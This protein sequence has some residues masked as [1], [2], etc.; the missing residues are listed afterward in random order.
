MLKT[1]FFALL[2]ILVTIC[3]GIFAAHRQAFT[4]QDSKKFVVLIMDYALP[5]H[6]FSGIW[7]AP[8]KIIIEDMP[9]ALW[10]VVSM[11]GCYLTL[12]LLQ[13]KLLK[14]P[15]KTATLRALSIADPSVPFIGSAILPLLFG[16]SISAIAIGISTLIINIILLPL[17]F[18]SLVSDTATRQFNLIQRL[19][20]T[21]KK[22]LVLSALAGFALALLGWQMPPALES[23]FTVLG[24]TAGGVAM[25]AT[26]IV[27]YV[28][29]ISFNKR[30]ISIV[31]GKNIIFPCIIWVSMFLLNMPNA[32]QRIVVV[33]LAIPTATMP[34]N[35][36][37][38]YKVNESEMA[39][40]QFWSTVLSFASLSIFMLLLS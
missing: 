36:A 31:I 34:T 26:G 35:L 33:T 14:T 12:M 20:N 16:A 15:N 39:S 29:K 8:R 7:A 2:P 23:T 5:L 28:R 22:P 24:K 30:I 25:F 27:L 21:L 32:L 17:V 4:E 13:T 3:L 18:T 1:V 40:V 11:F 37:I 9:L 6:V 19:H 10:L 38:Q